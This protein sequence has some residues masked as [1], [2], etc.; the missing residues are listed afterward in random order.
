MAGRQAVA[1]VGQQLRQLLGE[2][3]RRRLPVGVE[4]DRIRRMDFY[5]A[6]DTDGAANQSYMDSIFGELFEL[7]SGGKIIPDSPR[8]TPS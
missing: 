6:T 1:H 3:I 4:V 7:G 8:G 5:P 2:V